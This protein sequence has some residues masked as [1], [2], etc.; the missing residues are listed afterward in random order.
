MPVVGFF[1]NSVKAEKGKKKTTE[2]RVNNNANIKDVKKGAFD[3]VGEGVSIIFEY[4]AEYSDG[5]KISVGG[6]VF[7]VGDHQSILKTWKKD[8]KLPDGIHREVIN[9]ILRKCLIKAVS[10]ADDLQ[11]PP[12]IPIPLVA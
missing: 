4:I 5:S 3:P 11:L 9:A 1:I 6:E 8:G 10:L 2:L 7:Y 12:P